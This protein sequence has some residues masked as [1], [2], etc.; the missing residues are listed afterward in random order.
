MPIEPVEQ[1]VDQP[2]LRQLL[3]EQPKRRAVRYAVLKAK[4]EKPRERQPVAHLILDL[5]IRQIV[6]R[7]QY[8]HAEQ[9]Q[10]VEWFATRLA[11]LRLLRRHHHRLDIGAEALPR[12]QRSDR[13]QRIALLRQRRKPPIRVEKSQLPHPFAP[14][15]HVLANEIRIAPRRSQSFEVPLIK[16]ASPGEPKATKVSMYGFPYRSNVVRK[17][18]TVLQAI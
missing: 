7:L 1:L 13:F 17:F 3:T 4:P 14:Q 11:L 9:N 8:Q 18:R 6:Q 10:R 2:G 5:L 16:T 15:N 12:N